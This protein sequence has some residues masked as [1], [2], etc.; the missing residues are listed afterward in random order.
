MTAQAHQANVLGHLGSEVLVILEHRVG[1]AHQFAAV[2][3]HAAIDLFD[4]PD[5]IASCAK[6]RR[7][8]LALVFELESPEIAIL[9]EFDDA[10]DR[11]VGM[12]K[13]PCQARARLVHVE[14]GLDLRWQVPELGFGRLVVIEHSDGSCPLLDD[15]T[16]HE[17]QHLLALQREVDEEDV[18]AI[19][20]GGPMDQLAVGGRDKCALLPP[21][22][23]PDRP[24]RDDAVLAGVVIDADVRCVLAHDASASSLL[25]V[26]MKSP[27][28][29]TLSIGSASVR[30]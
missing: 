8:R 2:V 12:R 13:F 3:T 27:V 4:L 20:F 28:T 14:D 16:V 7:E 29:T 1:I 9:H 18:L 11:F 24:S 17:L 22:P 6:I 19:K 15:A 23:L 30:S 5:V 25:S 26:M 10:G 21:P